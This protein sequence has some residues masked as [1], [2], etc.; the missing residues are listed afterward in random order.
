MTDRAFRSLPFALLTLALCVGPSPSWASHS[1]FFSSLDRIEIDGNIFGPADGTPDFT[2]DFDDGVPGASWRSMMGTSTETSGVLT[3]HNPGMDLPSVPSMDASNV[4]HMQ[5]LVNGAGNYTITSYWLPILPGID[6]LFHLQVYG[7]GPSIEAA[8]ISVSNLS[9]TTAALYSPPG[10]PGLA[11]SQTLSYRDD[12]YADVEV[13]AFDAVPLDPASVTGIIA[14]RLSLDDAT[15]LLTTSFSLDGGATF[16]SPFPA[17][18][19]FA[20]ANVHHI[21]PGAAALEQRRIHPTQFLDLQ[22]FEV[23][24]RRST[25]TVTYFAKRYNVPLFDRPTDGGVTLNLALDGVTQCFHMPESDWKEITVDSN[26]RYTDRRRAHGP[27]KSARF[28]RY[29]RVFKVK[30]QIVGTADDVA[31]MPPNPGG[32]MDATL[33]FAGTTA[34]CTSSAGGSIRANTDRVFRVDEAPG[35]ATCTI[36]DCEP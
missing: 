11:I 35:P 32:Q 19:M 3:F 1:M 25:R 31:F 7:L 6:R 13:L 17:L 15:D 36:E 4:E 16:Q 30:V 22:S 9:A 34:Y 18:W 8:G 33:S 27:V 5:T 24:S 28:T 14:L 21:L 26:Y 12:G 20:R 29:G 10:L 23:K 2:D